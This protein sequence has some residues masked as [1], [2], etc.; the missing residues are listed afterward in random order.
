MTSCTLLNH[1]DSLPTF[2]LPD[3]CLSVSFAI[4]LTPPW[5]PGLVVI[6]RYLSLK[7]FLSSVC[8][9]PAFGLFAPVCLARFIN[10]IL[11][12]FMLLAVRFPGNTLQFSIWLRDDLQCIA[13]LCYFIYFISKPVF[14][15]TVCLGSPFSIGRFINFLVIFIPLPRPS[16]VLGSV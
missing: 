15:L 2:T 13:H 7:L 14:V 8:Q 4:Y 3:V 6:L 10:F 1:Y 12:L 16:L 9:L 5:F 11:A